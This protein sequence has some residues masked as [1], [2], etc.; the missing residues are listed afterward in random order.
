M[1]KVRIFPSL[2]AIADEFVQLL[3]SSTSIRIPGARPLY[4]ALS[5][6]TTPKLAYEKLADSQVDPALLRLYMVDE[7]YVPPTDDRS[8]ETMIRTALAGRFEIQGMYREGGAELAAKSYHDRLRAEVDKFD[9]VLLGMGEDGHTAS[10]FPGLWPEIPE[11][12]WCVASEAPGVC[13]E[14]IT[15]TPRALT[16]ARKTL[17]LATGQSKAARIR[18]V[19]EG[20]KDW[21]RLPAQSISDHSFSCEWWLDEAAGSQ[22]SVQAK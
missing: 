15:L 3:V 22:L 1:A 9:V 11:G 19:L 14:R 12:A 2:E 18:E 6:G 8:N 13:R 5:G 20:P 17:F 16:W 4:V 10:L 7:R 21:Q